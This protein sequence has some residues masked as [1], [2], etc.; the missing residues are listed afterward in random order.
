MKHILLYIVFVLL[1]AVLL[2]ICLVIRQKTK[3]QK[4]KRSTAT[5]ILEE[6]ILSS[7]PSS[8]PIELVSPISGKMISPD[9]TDEAATFISGKGCAILPSEG[10]LYAPCDCT[11]AA[12]EDENRLLVLSSKLGVELTVLIG[13]REPSAP[14][15]C[16]SP[17]CKAGDAVKVGDLLLSFDLEALE[18]DGFDLTALIQVDN[19]QDFSDI[20]FTDERKVSVGDKLI[21]LTPIKNPNGSLQ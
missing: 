10:K 15:S 8:I 6:A 9:D 18:I 4:A 3:K 2:F 13:S 21:T 5:V 12:I 16:F 19:A 7:K 11:V 1:L 17:C 14:Q 20:E